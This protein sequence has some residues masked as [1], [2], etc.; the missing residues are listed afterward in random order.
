MIEGARE[1]ILAWCLVEF[2]KHVRVGGKPV[3]VCALLKHAR[4]KRIAARASPRNIIPTILQ[5]LQKVGFPGFD[6]VGESAVAPH[7]RIPA[8]KH[9]DPARAADGVLTKRIGEARTLCSERI[10][11][12]RLHNRVAKRTDTVGAQLVR[13]EDQEIR[14]FA[15]ESRLRRL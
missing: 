10:Q 11:M 15:H 5:E 1:R 3:K 2:E 9:G 4:R 8:G 13:H 12:R 6:E 14:S 7:M